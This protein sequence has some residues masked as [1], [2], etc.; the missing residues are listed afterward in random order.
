MS[1]PPTPF[2]ELFRRYREATAFSREELAHKSNVPLGTI[3]RWDRGKTQTVQNWRYLLQTA[4]VL[5]LARGQTNSLLTTAGLPSLELLFQQVV[6]EKDQALFVSW[7]S[8]ITSLS[9][10]QQLL[11]EIPLTVVPP[12]SAP[13]SGS[14]IPFAANPHF[15]GRDDVL[16]IL[17]HRFYADAALDSGSKAI[18]AGLGG[19]GKTSI[20]VEFV[21]RYGCYFSGVFWL[22]FGDAAAIA[23]EV[24]ACGGPGFLELYRSNGDLTLDD[25]VRLVQNAW[26]QNIPRLLVFDNCDDPLLV[27]QWLPMTG[28]CRVLI[29]SQRQ[30]WPSSF[31]IPVYRLDILD[32]SASISL[33]QGLAP[34]LLSNEAD[35]I[36]EELGD[37][38][39]ALQ[40]AGSYLAEFRWTSSEDYINE[41][42]N[43]MIMAHPS[44]R[45][46]HENDIS[47]TKHDRDVER[48]FLMSY[49]RLDPQNE[50]DRMASAILIRAACFAPGMLIPIELLLTSVNLRPQMMQGQ[51]AIGRLA[52][53]GLMIVEDTGVR[54]HRL[55]ANFAQAVI[56]DGT[57]QSTVEESLITHVKNISQNGDVSSMKRMLVHLEWVIHRGANRVE[58]AMAQLWFHWGLCLKTIGDFR[59][60]Q[61]AYEHALRLYEITFGDKHPDTATCLNSLAE[62]YWSM[63]NFAMAQTHYERALAIE[64]D[65]FGRIHATTAKTLNDLGAV[66][67]SLGDSKTACM[68]CKE[69]LSIFETTLGSIH[70]AT[71]ESLNN[72][73]LFLISMGDYESAYLP[74]EQAIAIY[75]QTVGSAHPDM[76][77]SLNNRALLMEY[78]G[79]FSEA[80]ALHER[81]LAIREQIQGPKHPATAQSLYNLGAFMHTTGNF[82]RSFYF[83]ERAIEIFTETWGINHPDT[84]TSIGALATLLDSMA[85]YKRARRFAEQA[86]SI[87][88]SVLG[89]RH[90]DVAVSLNCLARV[91][92]GLGEYTSAKAL[93]ERALVICDETENDSIKAIYLNN[94][95]RTLQ[96]MKDYNAAQRCYE[97]AVSMLKETLGERHPDV[98]YGLNN[99]GLLY[100]CLGDYKIARS[101][102]EEA[103]SIREA[104]VDPDHPDIATSLRSLAE[105]YQV[106]EEYTAA[107][108]L[109]ERALN[110]QTTML[111]TTH[112]DTHKTKNQLVTCMAALDRVE[113]ME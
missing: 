103:L 79:K 6:D 3:K 95:G 55:V 14:R 20:A 111:G 35:A 88:E 16:M 48:T 27:Q 77:T 89:S 73:G 67:Y 12:I 81:A 90:P 10:M 78:V 104:T 93:Y 52:D 47:T 28:G 56:L 71:A 46:E 70:A 86:L 51:A 43:A 62:V 24:A 69:A 96:S 40:L 41:L 18:L 105:L 66:A 8:D 38:P 61:P 87:R 80:H 45:G 25:Q 63:G 50:Q 110:I 76:A 92:D 113:Q 53:L 60:A 44:L 94:L 23:R 9:G 85:D 59:S 74:S 37:L 98:A 49:R 99:L 102:L 2:G 75:E 97:Q 72:L 107:R 34:R 83:Y 33:L 1:I 42:R 11:N 19:V 65:L 4:I 13:P 15:V 21:R 101:V 112:P 57:A 5:K 64:E 54:L 82:N 29:T 58:T 84:A 39:L 22:N 7:K 106:T 31:D 91:L 109:L 17:A 30:R 108:V 36:A 26:E 32:R 100:Q 68:L